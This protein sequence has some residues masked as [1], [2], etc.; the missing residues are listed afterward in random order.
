MP[1]KRVTWKP[2][3]RGQSLG[4]TWGT[5]V[6][7]AGR[8]RPIHSQQ[9][10]ACSGRWS[11]G[12]AKSSR[13]Q[14]CQGVLFARSSDRTCDRSDILSWVRPAVLCPRGNALLGQVSLLRRS[15]GKAGSE[16]G[17]E[18]RVSCLHAP[19]TAL[20]PAR[21]LAAGS[22]QHPTQPGGAQSSRLLEG[23]PRRKPS[24]P[25]GGEESPE[26]HR[27]LRERADMPLSSPGWVQI[28]EL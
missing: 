15:A 13:A 26:T 11:W 17:T 16:I 2:R 12:E 9:G 1:Y 27:I 22:R 20:K 25:G 14:W 3:L 18:A 7:P 10:G 24:P 6:L 21:A 8:E 23:P 4:E 5:V 19:G 28:K